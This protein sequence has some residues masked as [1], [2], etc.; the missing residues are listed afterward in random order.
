M[1]SEGF[2]ITLPTL[3]CWSKTH[4]L[5]VPLNAPSS[6][7]P[8]VIVFMG[9]HVFLLEFPLNFISVMSPFKSYMMD[10]YTSIM[11]LFSVN[12]CMPLE[13][14]IHFW[15]NINMHFLYNAYVTL[16]R[17]CTLWVPSFPIYLSNFLITDI[18]HKHIPGTWGLLKECYFSFLHMWDK[19]V[20]SGGRDYFGTKNW[21]LYIFPE[22]RWVLWMQ[23]VCLSCS[24]PCPQSQSA[25]QL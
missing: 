11:Y 24:L 12:E 19:L 16:G 23:K 21:H 15:A 5:R 18:K 2:I 9:S 22:W 4:S 1:K 13:A 8:S 3:A 7:I 20:Y 17:H 6:V 10:S 25:S 14:K